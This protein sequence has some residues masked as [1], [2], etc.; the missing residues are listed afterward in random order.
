MASSVAD[1]AISAVRGGLVYCRDDPFL[2]ASGAALVHEP[3]GLVIC[4]AGLIDKVG[5]Y[6]ALAASLPDGADIANYSGCL[7][8]PGFIDT[9]LHY[10]QTGIIGAQGG[11]LL[12]WLE[13]YTIR[14]SSPSPTMWWPARQPSCSATSS[15]GTAPRPPW[16]S[17]RCMRDRS[18]RYSRRRSGETC[19]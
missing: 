14:R 19:A 9:H 12:D 11:E 1:A 7:I 4:R 15:S 3:D 6:S 13:R 18:M 17:A 16:Y 5:S 10:V 2:V 8:A